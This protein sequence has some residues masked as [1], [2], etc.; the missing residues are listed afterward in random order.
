MAHISLKNFC[1]IITCVQNNP[2]GAA[3]CITPY[4]HF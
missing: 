3:A 4:I 2:E 1:K